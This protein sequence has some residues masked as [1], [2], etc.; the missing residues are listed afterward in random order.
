MEP[1]AQTSLAPNL[2]SRHPTFS[3]SV[4]HGG[5][6][7]AGRVWGAISRRRNETGRVAGRITP[8]PVVSQAAPPGG[9]YSP[10]PSNRRKAVLPTVVLHVFAVCS[11]N[12]GEGGRGAALITS[13][14]E[15]HTFSS[16]T[17]RVG[18]Q[19]V[20]VGGDTTPE[21]G[22]TGLRRECRRSPAVV[23]FSLRVISPCGG[24]RGERQLK[25]THGIFVFRPL[26]RKT[27]L[28]ER[29][30]PSSAVA[31][32]LR[33]RDERCGRDRD[34]LGGSA[35]RRLDAERLAR[36]QSRQCSLRASP[37]ARSRSAAPRRLA[38]SRRGDAV[39]PRSRAEEL[40]WKAAR[41][42]RERRRKDRALEIGEAMG[43]ASD[44]H[45]RCRGPVLASDVLCRVVVE[46][47]FE[48]AHNGT[49]EISQSRS[50]RVRDAVGYFGTTEKLGAA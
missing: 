18:L 5:A 26:E 19:G 29:D 32:S 9:G 35:S 25:P 28:R 45:W 13:D 22:R 11:G 37:R 48:E 12:G 38:F 34:G 7:N 36:F 24:D 15:M 20:G 1:G 30:R 39:G 17:G 10:L 3:L 44:H 46:A 14:A 2:S 31:A 40:R 21:G 27:G 16:D 33:I 47:L 23:R 43:N 42:L 41:D 50:P 8:D 6:R 4:R 49:P